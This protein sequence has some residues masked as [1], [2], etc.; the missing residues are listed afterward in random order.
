ME[1]DTAGDPITG[2]KWTHKTTEKVAEELARFD[3]VVSAKTVGRLLKNLGFSLRVN[4]KAIESGNKNPPTP[5]DRDRQFRFIKRMREAFAEA[6][7]PI[8][9]VD[10]KKRELVGN[11]KN[12]GQS[13][14]NKT[15]KV[16][17]H[18]FPSDA[19]GVAVIYGIYG[20]QTNRGD[21]F[22]GTS[23][24]TPAFSARC[25]IDWWK[26]VGRKSW[27]KAKEIL[28]LA[29]SGG[30]NSSR[31]RVW[32]YRLYHQLCKPFGITVTV[33]HYPPGTSKWNPI[34]HRLFAE[35]SK[36]WAGQPLVSYEKILKYLRTTKTKTRLRV[37]ARLINKLYQTGEKIANKE[38]N[39]IPIQRHNIF[40][41]WNYTIS[42]NKM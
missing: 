38:M 33:C 42:Q 5:K 39:E 28:I 31:S 17:D 14:E 41:N 25:I 20:I 13:W 11:F 40:P 10:S 8:I 1:H 9:S 34:E 37:A 19:D 26:Q 18:D 22:V 36:N 23:H 29:D 24:D 30:S 3:I 32:K 7:N 12:N 21:V 15:V 2:L 27:P 4:H 6:A 35:V 16:K